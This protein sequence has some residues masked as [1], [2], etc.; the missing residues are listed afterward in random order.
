MKIKNN[1]INKYNDHL[2]NLDVMEKV[3]NILIYNQL[4]IKID[5]IHIKI[6]FIK[7]SFFNKHQQKVIIIR[8]LV[9]LDK[10]NKNSFD[11]LT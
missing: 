2:I 10:K 3:I 9:L 6:V 1:L 8:L 7:V 11:I 5:Y 4:L